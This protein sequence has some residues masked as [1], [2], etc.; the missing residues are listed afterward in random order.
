VDAKN[1][2]ADEFLL[3]FSHEKGSIRVVMSQ[4][5]NCDKIHRVRGTAT[6]SETFDGRVSFYSDTL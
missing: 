4:N 3:A 1:F 5:R 6:R 2:T